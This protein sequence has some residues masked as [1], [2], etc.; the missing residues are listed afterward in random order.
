MIHEHSCCNRA[1]AAATS[2]WRAG[3]RS[4]NRHKSCGLGPGPLLAVHPASPIVL[5]G[6]APGR[7]VHESWVPWNDRSGGRLCAWFGIFRERFYDRTAVS[8]T[9]M[10]FCVPGTRR[11]GD[12]A[13]PAEC[14]PQWH[15]KLFPFLRSLKLT[16]YLGHYAF[17]AYKDLLP[18]ASPSLILPPERRSG[19]RN[20]R[21]LNR[22]CFPRLR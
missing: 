12:I 3:C 4:T 6:Q 21:G 9:P 14:V 8:I 20:T 13:P 11:Q 16:G 19:S 1:F 7:A 5:I 17:E 10:G 18:G 15:G 2:L 22:E